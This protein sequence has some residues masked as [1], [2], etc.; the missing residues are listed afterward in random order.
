MTKA[1]KSLLFLVIYVYMVRKVEAQ[2]IINKEPHEIYF[3]ISNLEN[4]PFWS[5]IAH[6]ETVSGSGEVGSIYN[7]ITPTLIGKRK[8]PIEVTQKSAHALFAF[9]DNTAPYNNETGFKLEGLEGKTRIIAYQEVGIGTVVSLLTLN[10]ITQRDS[11]RNLSKMLA[12]LASV[13]ET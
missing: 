10:F 4:L 9:K 12:R 5:D 11:K 7:I 6:I 3:Y 1:C 8:T 2:R 13:L